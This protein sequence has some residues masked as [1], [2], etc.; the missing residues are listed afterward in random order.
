M[1]LVSVTCDHVGILKNGSIEERGTP[2]E[3]I[4]SP[5]KDYTRTLLKSLPDKLPPVIPDRTKPILRVRNLKK[6]FPLRSGFFGGGI[7]NIKAVDG[8]DLDIYSGD[9]LGIVGE[10]G[11]GKTTLINVLLNLDKPSSGEVAFEG[12]NLFDL[13]KKQMRSMR[14]NIQVVFQDPFWSLDPRILIRDIVGEPLRVHTKP[15]AVSYNSKVGE[16]LELVGLPADSAFRF[17][18]EFSGGQR[19]RIAIARSLALEAKFIVL[20]EPTS[21]IDVVSQAQILQ[22]LEQL[23][24]RYHLTYVVISHDLSVVHFMATRII[25][26]YLGRIVESGPADTLFINPRHPYTQALMGAIPRLDMNG[27]EELQVI[28]GNVPSAIDIPPGCRFHTRCKRAQE[29]C[30]LEE[31]VLRDQGDDVMTACHFL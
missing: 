18:H 5:Q 16:L 20:D 24:R 13:P 1:G 26:M 29:R 31:P 2:R 19:Q 3:I 4:A 17:P 30:R 7:K 21:S 27:L 28:E 8:V 11:C 15:D 9:T 6:Y 22:L 12:I 25:V 23:K 10:S 14:R